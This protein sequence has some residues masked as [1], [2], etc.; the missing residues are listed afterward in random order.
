MLIFG[1][2]HGG[3][4]FKEQLK[5]SYQE[6]NEEIIDCGAHELNE[7]DD[8]PTFA[9][10]VAQEIRKKQQELPDTQESIVGVLICRSAGG[11]VITA[12]RHPGVRAVHCR[13]IDDAMHAREHNHANIIAI[14]GDS[15]GELSLA[16]SLINVF[17]STNWSTEE[18]HVRRVEQIDQVSAV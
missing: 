18:R 17:R 3:F 14:S 6:S 1:C 9:H 2:D 13:T 11:V 7:Q 5:Q 16:Q 4:F 12:N 15:Q 10:A 8:Y